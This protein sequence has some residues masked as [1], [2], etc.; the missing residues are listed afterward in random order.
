MTII[1]AI[2]LGIVQGITEFLPISSSAH[3]VL[4]PYLFK[5]DVQSETDFLFNVLIQLGTLLAVFIFFK[6]DVI[7]ISKAWIQSVFKPAES[8]REDFRFGWYI[9]LATLPAVVVGLTLKPHIQSIFESPLIT[10]ILL[11]ITAVLLFFAEHLKPGKFLIMQLTWKLVLVIGLFQAFALFPG[12][13]RSGATIFAGL[14]VGLKSQE[15]GRFSFLLSIPVLLGAG[16]LSFSDLFAVQNIMSF[17]PL[18]AAGFITSTIVGY[19]SI[20]ILMKFLQKY[21]L[22][23]FSAYCA[24]VGSIIIFIAYAA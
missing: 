18:L 8:N 24:I 9:I 10:G 21:S 5:W 16:I 20:A 12:I 7:S 4:F 14:L 2:I 11:L 22:L 15:A 6:N 23:Y 13:S 19:F 17:L 1:Q 3:L